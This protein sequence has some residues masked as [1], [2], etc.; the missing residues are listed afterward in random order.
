MYIW[1]DDIRLIPSDIKHTEKQLR[2]THSVNETKQFIEECELNHITHF[3]LDLDHDLGNYAYDG[4]DAYKLVIWLIETG[5]NTSN[6]VL[7]FHTANPV[8]RENMEALYN[9]YWEG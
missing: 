6:Y 9:R 5:R 7:K 8:G 4:G 2:H 1:L 3:V